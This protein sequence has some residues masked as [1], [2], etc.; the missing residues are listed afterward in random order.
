MGHL[1]RQRTLCLI[2]VWTGRWI[3]VKVFGVLSEGINAFDL[4]KCLI[5]EKQKRKVKYT[6]IIP[7]K[8]TS[9]LL[10]KAQDITICTFLSLY[11]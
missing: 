3:N 2:H 5:K 11:F 6:I 4:D 8:C 10:L 7:T 1:T 9:F